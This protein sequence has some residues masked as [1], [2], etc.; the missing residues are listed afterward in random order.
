MFN[1]I[2]LHGLNSNHQAYKGRLLRDYCQQHLPHIQV[3][4][5]D[6]NMPPQHVIRMLSEQI[7]AMTPH[8]V[9]LVGS[10]LGGFFATVLHQKYACPTVLLNPSLFPEQSLKR[11]VTRDLDDYQLDEI[12]YT[13]QGG[14]DICKQDLLW[15]ID[16]RPRQLQHT[17]HLWLMLKQGDEVLD[18]R[19]SLDY[20]HQHS[21]YAPHIL[22]EPQGNH[23]M[24]DFDEK[25]AM[26]TQF[27]TKG[28]K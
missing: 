1:I 21:E 24:T 4:S 14:W 25:L 27:L 13:T 28:K 7:E 8:C 18:Y 16:H 20:F 11:F 6:L 15:F 2:Y 12:L 10:S 23:V 9:A 22:L 5:P 26:I 17:H 3:H 19:L